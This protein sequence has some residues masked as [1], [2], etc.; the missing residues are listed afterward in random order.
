MTNNSDFSLDITVSPAT[1]FKPLPDLVV[2]DLCRAYPMSDGN[3]LL[4]NARNNKRVVVMPEVY[5]SLLSCNQFQ[6]LNQHVARIIESNP[7]MQDQQAD[8][9]KVLQNMLDSGMMVSAKSVTSKLKSAVKIAPDEKSH[10]K[11]VVAIITWERPEA[12]ERLLESIVTNCATGDFHRLYVIDDS[13]K[14]TNISKNQALVEKVAPSIDA[15]IQY[16]GRDEQN[17][18]LDDLVKQLPGQEN[19]IRFLAD[20]S[21]WEEHWTSGLSRNLALLLSC[22]HRLV[23]LDDDTVCDVYDPPQPKSNI[24]FSDA[25]READFFGDEQEWAP[26]HQPMNP[27]PVNRHMQCL[28]LSFSDA[29]G[30]L[31]ESHLK[32][33]AFSDATALMVSELQAD[34]PVLMTECGS[35]GCP[36]TDSNTW[37]PDMA[38]SSIGQMLLSAK[39][40]TN[41][42]TRRKVWTGRNQPHFSPRSNM[43]QITGF[44]N[45]QVLPPYLPIMR[46]EDRLFGFMLD[47][48][49]PSALTL[50]YP[51]AVPHLPIPERKWENRNLNFTPCDSFPMF[52]F[53]KVLEYKSSSRSGSYSDRMSALSAWFEDM[54]AA[55]GETLTAMYRDARLQG[56]SEHLQHLGALLSTAESAPVDW[57]NYLRNGITQLNA[58]LDKASQEDFPV[59][60]LPAT[61]EGDELISFWKETWGDFADALSAWPEI[62]VAAAKI[63]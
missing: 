2:F 49:F 63:M 37:L 11:P 44:D 20:H 8:I 17:S 6:T 3:L 45:R 28:G 13:R 60:G 23:M 24:T 46:G 27:D 29:L 21:R 39:K 59:R 9:R 10:G 51:W 32:P 58:D 54:A 43:S 19:A 50:D 31:G 34:S 53:E 30:V 47:F 40:T 36:G 55:P 22:G 12:L 52:F 1:G 25:P 48:I 16:F 41:A 42:L 56:N 62:R 4:L 61:M 57:Q 5:A 38:P 15:P 35:L 14:S 33:A 7:G 18:L 26:L